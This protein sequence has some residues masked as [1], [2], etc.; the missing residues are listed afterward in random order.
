MPN[1]IFIG[2]T[3]QLEPYHAWSLWSYTVYGF[4]V[5]VEDAGLALREVRPGIDGIALIQ[6]QWNGRR[7]EDSQWFQKSPLN[8][9]VDDWGAATGRKPALINARK[10][11][12]CG[13]F[14]FL[15]TEARSR[16]PRSRNSSVVSERRFGC[17][18]LIGGE[19]FATGSR[20]VGCPD[21]FLATAVPAGSP[22]ESPAT[23]HRLISLALVG[24]L[25][26]SVNEPV[27]R[28]TYPGRTS[29][30]SSL[31]NSQEAAAYWDARHVN[32]DELR[33]GGHRGLD[34]ASNEIFYALRLGR[35]LEIIGDH[36]STTEPLFVLD[37]GCGKGWFTRALTRFGHW[38][39]GIDASPEAIKYGT[40]QGGAQGT[41]ARRWR[42]GRARG[43]TTSSS[44]ST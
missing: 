19:C 21:S 41:T 5:I 15:A 28:G 27:S 8:S 40:E 23:C 37:A 39:E 22:R 16:R 13:Q 25:C 6:R 9:K 29:V 42:R 20:G 17:Y 12:F 3:S 10:L 33:S 34:Y 11:Q 26:V 24:P 35:L 30:S 7:P 31:L 32:D 36:T 2:S 18:L 43:C 44:A 14:S 1:G 4:R 38:V